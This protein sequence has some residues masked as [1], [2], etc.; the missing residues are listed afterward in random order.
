[1]KSY[2]SIPNWE[3]FQHYKD[4]NPPWIKLHNQLLENYD[5]EC[6]P[7]A[8]KAHL[9]CI[10]LLAS[11]TENKFINDS[12]WIGRKIGANTE[13]DTKV[14]VDSGFLQLNQ[15]DKADASRVLHT[16]EQ[17]AGTE[18]EGEGEGEESREEE[19]REDLSAITDDQQ[20]SLTDLDSYSL[21]ISQGADPVTEIFNY[22][23]TTMD[24]KSNT[25]F[26]DKRKA[27]IKKRLEDGYS[28]SDI[29]TA[30]FNC[31]NTDH[32]MGRGKNTN[33]TKYNDVELICRNPENLER[34][35][36][37][38]GTGRTEQDNDEF[39]RGGLSPVASPDQQDGRTF[40]HDSF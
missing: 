12:R 11:R 4:R 23:V 17:N 36:D 19:S 1:M 15:E 28:V 31:S 16:S 2:L 39:D 37:N 26:S 32:N 14:L 10:W 33:G 7:D 38:P 20:I 22:W 35:R 30:I 9:L 13:V 18:G 40:D 5:F 21:T 6:L 24:K 27:N 34:F 25:A 29:K 3:E 8:S